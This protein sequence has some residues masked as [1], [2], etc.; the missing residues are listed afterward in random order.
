M[1]EYRD[2]YSTG[3]WSEREGHE[4][5]YIIVHSTEG[6]R[7]AAFAWWSSPENP[8]K[9][10]AHD[11]ID[12]T[13]VVWR[14]VP[15]DKASHHAGGGHIAGFN[16][17]N[18]E[19]GRYEPSINLAS[20]GIELEYPAAPASP[21]WPAVQV[22][23][24]VAHVRNLVSTYQIA[25]ANVLRHAD[26]DPQNRTDPRNLPW[27]EFM[28][29]VFQT[30]DTGIHHAARN[31]AWNAGGIPYN[32]DATFPRYARERN[33]GNPETPEFDFSFGGQKF[34]GQGFSRG[35]IYAR[36]GEWG[37]IKEVPW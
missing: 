23:V 27:E 3:Y 13:G 10:S 25:R 7:G 26:I 30:D 24:A 1:P 21:P 8:F 20:I 29:R 22:D 19:T 12:S 16:E 11:L 36:V 17:R 14:C 33:L 34:R 2:W 6:P 18:P 5:R 28:N 37:Q 32:P 9:S 35:I 31:A 15:Y 4:I